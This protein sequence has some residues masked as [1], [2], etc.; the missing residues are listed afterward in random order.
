MVDFTNEYF[1]IVF[2]FRGSWDF[3][4]PPEMV[5]FKIKTNGFEGPNDEST[6]LSEVSSCFTN[7]FFQN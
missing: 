7:C 6:H 5:D 4:I 1:T 2:A 3:E